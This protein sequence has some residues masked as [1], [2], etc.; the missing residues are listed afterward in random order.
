MIRHSLGIRR[1][2]EWKPGNPRLCIAERQLKDNMVLPTRELVFLDIAVV[3]S[4][5]LIRMLT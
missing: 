4:A 3:S 1:E 5:D 2:A